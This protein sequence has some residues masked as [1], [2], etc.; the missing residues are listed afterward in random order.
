MA[1]PRGDVVRFLEFFVVFVVSTMISASKNEGRPLLPDRRLPQI[2]QSAAPCGELR[3]T[4]RIL[5]HT[6]S[7]VSI[8]FFESFCDLL[9]FLAVEGSG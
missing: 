2:P 9:C 8:E 6:V 1:E 3:R 7:V 5:S 4:Y